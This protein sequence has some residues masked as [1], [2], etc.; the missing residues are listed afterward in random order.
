MNQ[1]RL[2]RSTQLAE[3]DKNTRRIIAAYN[4]REDE[5]LRQVEK[6]I[7]KEMNTDSKKDR[8]VNNLRRRSSQLLALQDFYGLNDKGGYNPETSEHDIREYLQLNTN[9]PTTTT[10]NRSSSVVVPPNMAADSLS[11]HTEKLRRI[12]LHGG[13]DRI[14]KFSNNGLTRPILVHT[15]ATQLEIT[16]ES[17]SVKDGHRQRRISRTSMDR[18]TSQLGRPAM[19]INNHSD[20]Y[21]ETEKPLAAILPP[22]VLPPIYKVKDQE[23]KYRNY[24]ISGPAKNMSEHEWKDLKYCR[25]LRPKSIKYRSAQD[26]Q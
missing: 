26:M 12:S 24:A 25:Y 19:D 2:S 4:N 20:I 23:L 9:V 5:K 1:R 21:V 18:R 16:K 10:R 13:P 17:G 7:D 15:D 8:N 3:L 14:R 6:F 22:V 11:D